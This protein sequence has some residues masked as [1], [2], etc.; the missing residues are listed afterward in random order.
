M[1]LVSRRNVNELGGWYEIMDD[2][3]MAEISRRAG[4]MAMAI[5]Q[6]ASGQ[7]AWAG[8]LAA[9][10]FPCR[11]T[12]QE[13]VELLKMPTCFGR[14]GGSCSTTW[15]TATAGGSTTTGPSFVTPKSRDWTWTSPHRRSGPMPENRSTDA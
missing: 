13:L 6:A 10:P 11:L 2:T 8:A 5:G 7:F 3:S 14:R 4:F 9:E 15:A 1:G 12:T